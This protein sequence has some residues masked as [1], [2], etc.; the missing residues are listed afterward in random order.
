[1]AAPEN[2]DDLQSA[3]R[4]NAELIET[5]ER[6]QKANEQLREE[7][8][9]YRRK[10]FGRSSERHIED[11]SQLHL[12]DMGDQQPENEGTE[13]DQ[14]AEPSRRRRRKKKSEKLPDHLK[15][16]IVEADVSAEQRICPCCGEEMPMRNPAV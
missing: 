14:E 11:D 1:M 15:R 9:L 6:L 4:L 8:N 10:F 16:K 7:L 5:V 2:K 12:F 3:L 13:D